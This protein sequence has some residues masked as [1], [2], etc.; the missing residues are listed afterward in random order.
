MTYEEV[1]NI[2][3]LDRET[4]NRYVEY[5]RK[6]WNDTEEQKCRDGYAGQ[7]AQRFKL[8]YEYQASDPNGQSV[9]KEIDKNRQ[10]RR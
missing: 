2:A 1:A 4:K 9:L 10:R 7:W 6:R 5:M 8:K 3:G